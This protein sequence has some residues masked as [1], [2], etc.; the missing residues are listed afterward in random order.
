MEMDCVSKKSQWN[1]TTKNKAVTKNL[2]S[3]MVYCIPIGKRKELYFQV[4]KLCASKF[5]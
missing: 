3:K 4:Y 2:T 1:F 5:Y